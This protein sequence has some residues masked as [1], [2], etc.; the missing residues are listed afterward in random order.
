MTLLDSLIDRLREAGAKREADTER[1][2]AF[3]YHAETHSAGIGAGLG[4]AAALTGQWRLVGLVVSIGV[5]AARGKSALDPK[6][7]AD[8]RQEP[9]YALGGL[10]L[11][12]CIGLVARL[13]V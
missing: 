2:G 8:V 10:V 7:A 3:S 4:M 12:V 1:D 11:G 6:I 5:Y 13:I 9:H